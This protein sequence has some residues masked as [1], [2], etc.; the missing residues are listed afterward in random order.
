MKNYSLKHCLR[1]LTMHL[2]AL[3]GVLI[4][5]W[6][7]TA[8]GFALFTFY[9]RH[10][11][12]GGFYHRYFSHR[13]FKTSRPFQ[14]VMAFWG[15]TSGHKGPLSW[16]TSHRIHHK[17]AEKPGDPHSPKVLGFGR[18]Y[19][20]WLLQEDALPTD[21]TLMKDFSSYPEIIWIN[22]YHFL[23]PLTFLGFTAAV[24]YFIENNFPSLQTTQMQI[25]VWGFLVSTLANAHIAMVINTFCHLFGTRRYET[26]D[27]SYNIWWLMPFSI[28]E[29][30]HNNH[31]AYPKLA[32]SGLKWWELDPIYWGIQ[33]L[34]KLGLVWDVY[35]RSYAKERTLDETSL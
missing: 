3:A 17:Y 33:L 35:D 16:A 26:R 21:M 11:A 27:E 13:S 29:N 32:A 8:V 9:F 5:G 12:V 1:I 14:F 2:I 18:A 6:S 7:W 31:H 15:T 19:I 10:F 28:G 34:A 22:K 23:G 25:I 24:G 30:W 4:Y 20:G